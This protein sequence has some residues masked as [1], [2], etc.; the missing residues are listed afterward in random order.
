MLGTLLTET[1]AGV[2][3]RASIIRAQQGKMMEK[4][5]W[6][7]RDATV[8]EHE[9]LYIHFSIFVVVLFI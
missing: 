1:L 5:A 3:L 2:C 7:D 9:E 4:S 6:E 8:K